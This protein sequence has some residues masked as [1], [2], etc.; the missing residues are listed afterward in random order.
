MNK[1]LIFIKNFFSN[2]PKKKLTKNKNNFTYSPIKGYFSSIDKY[3]NNYIMDS[4]SK[5]F[6]KDN[7]ISE[8]GNIYDFLDKNLYTWVVDPLCGTTNHV[9]QIPF[10]AISISVFKNKKIFSGV[11]DFLRDEFFYTNGISSYLNKKKIHTSDVKKLNQSVIAIN[12]NQ[13]SSGAT[14]LKKLISIFNPPVVRR[15][16]IIE[17]ANLELAYVACGRLDAYIN[18]DDKIWDML[19]ASEIIK[20]SGGKCYFF[21]GNLSQPH[22]FKGIMASNRFI[23]NQIYK[24]IYE[25]F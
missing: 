4:I 1:R 18:P 8:E 2:L 3:L 21:K 16:K 9:K 23:H 19:G 17:S 5:E 25:K 10:Y 7:I 20:K 24:K 13:S 12:C 14:S 11:Y 6:P 22:N 15:I